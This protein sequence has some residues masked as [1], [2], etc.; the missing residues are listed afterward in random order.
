M[1]RCRHGALVCAARGAA[2][3]RSSGAPLCRQAAAPMAPSFLPPVDA[4]FS[5]ARAGLAPDVTP[6]STPFWRAVMEAIN[7]RSIGPLGGDDHGEFNRCSVSQKWQQK[8][9]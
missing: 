6:I 3:R 7:P 8:P 9:R 5:E 2:S 4:L 1:D